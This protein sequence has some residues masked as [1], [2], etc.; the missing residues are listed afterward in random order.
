MENFEVIVVGGGPGGLSSAY[1]AARE[2]A[3]VA[4]VE[5]LGRLGG[6][7]VLSTGHLALIDTPFQRQHGVH[8]SVELFMDDAEKQFELEK[9]KGGFI[10]DK[11]LTLLFAR[12]SAATYDEITGLGLAVARLDAKPSQHTADRLHTLK[13]P[14]ELGPV[15]AEH[16]QALGVRIML[17]TEVD[18]LITTGGCVAGVR[19]NRRLSDSS[20]E[21]VGLS[22][23]KGVILAT[24]GYQGNF[25]LR[26]RYQPVSEINK[27]IVGVNS[28]RGTGHIL[29]ASVGGDLINMGYIQPMILVPT[30]LVQD[31]IAVNLDGAR[32]HDEAGPYARRVESLARQPEQTAYYIV[33]SETLESKRAFVERMPE[34]ATIHDSLEEVAAATGCKVEGLARSVEE[35]NAFLESGQRK[36]P[37]TRRVLLPVNRRKI[38]KPPFAAIRMVRGIS[39]TWGGLTTT[40]D[41]QVV[42]VQGRVVPGL[43][44]VGDTIGGINVLA[45]M[46][47]LHIS[48]AITLG[49]I[50]GRAAVSGPGAAAHICA[51]SQAEAFEP[52]ASQKFVLF[53]LDEQKP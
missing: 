39:F 15:Y 43:F 50:A 24:G 47:G 49:R 44:A 37:A 18:D 4:L 23:S 35:W 32:F 52:S 14:T 22:A 33:D 6:N 28:C 10:W 27:H 17:H 8:D 38:C 31:A 12:E 20:V 11:E 5:S 48:P 42:T 13:D 7:G 45:G 29:G 36:D 34:P 40:L 53:D 9:G 16:L 1:T 25:E 30:G 26:R 19:G 3:K 2:G 21:R 41:M 46:G 51:P